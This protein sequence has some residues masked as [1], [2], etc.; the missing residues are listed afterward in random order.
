VS[1]ANAYDFVVVGAGTAGCAVANR[2][3]ASGRFTVLLLEAG[4]EDRNP[5]IHIPLGT[6]RVFNDPDLNWR[7]ESEPEEA[8]A[9]RRMYQ[10]RGKVLG[11]TGSINGMIYC[12]GN[13]ADYDTWAAGGCTGWSYEDVLP[14]F[15]AAEDQQRGSDRFHGTGGPVSVSG[16]QSPHVLADA[17]IA[18]AAQQGVPTNGDFNGV[19][20]EGAGY[21]QYTVKRGRRSSPATA[22]LRPA[23]HRA[24][25]RVRTRALVSRVI[26]EGTR[27]AG[28]EFST[29]GKVHRARAAQEVILCGGTFNS[30]QLLQLSG[31]GPPGLLQRL[32]LKVVRAS[33]KVGENYHDHFG[34]RM[35]YRCKQRVT[36]NDVMSSPWRKVRMGLQYAISRSGPMAAPGLPAGAFV[37]S[38]P[39]LSA[40]DLELVLSL[41]TMV[42]GERNKARVV[43]PYSAFGMVI[44]D[45]HPAGRGSVRIKSADAEIAPEIRCNLFAT[46]RDERVILHAIRFARR[47]FRAPA[48]D[49]YTGAELLPGEEAQSDGEL[50]HYVRHNGFGLYHPV[51]TCAMG[52]D[53][54][55]VLDPRL[56]V[57]GVHGLRVVDASVMPRITSGNINATVGMI[58]EKGSAMILEDA[59]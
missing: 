32:G 17:F 51:G 26:F 16:P 50:L 3:S 7:Y 36:L 30:P 25:L 4:G 59:R 54:S 8:L 42:Q 9:G 11:G 45:L 29:G 6:G 35:A 14:Y 55:D 37:R 38:D 2:L 33:A 24:N 49:A 53:E 5:W 52:S 40:P 47:I 43:D 22:Y 31:V 15:R 28:V 44:E 48:L 39:A 1:T 34:V 46:A 56:K 57:R 58:G 41:W 20:Q 13:P 12:R 19:R 23:R 21:F 27:A 10:P 18:S